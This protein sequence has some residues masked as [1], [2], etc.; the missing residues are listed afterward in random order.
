MKDKKVKEY[1]P[2]HIR[3]ELHTELKQ[4]CEENGY[5]MIGILTKIIKE[6]IKK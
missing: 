5:S 4:W 2:V 3:K 6:Q 1:T